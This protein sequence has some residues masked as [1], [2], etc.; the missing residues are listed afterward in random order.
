MKDYLGNNVATGDTVLVAMRAGRT[1]TLGRGFVKD[2]KMRKQFATG[3]LV[4]MVEVEWSNI[5]RYWMPARHVVYLPPEMLPE[6]R[7][8]KLNDTEEAVQPS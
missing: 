4:A 8:E 3:P 1:A 2:M 6:K 7:R 5:H